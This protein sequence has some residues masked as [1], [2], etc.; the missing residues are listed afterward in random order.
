MVKAHKGTHETK[1]AVD[2]LE[3]KMQL[4]LFVGRKS[5]YSPMEDMGVGEEAARHATASGSGE[6]DTRTGSQQGVWCM[7]HAR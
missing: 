4:A 2:N 7:E 6:A 1:P 5:I 3:K